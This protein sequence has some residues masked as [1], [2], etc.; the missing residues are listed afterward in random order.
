[1]AYAILRT[2]K[3]TT[4]GNVAASLQHNFRERPTLNADPERTPLNE[5]HGATST[6]QAMG[7]LRSLLPERRRKDAVL[8]IEYFCGASPE[9]WAK[10]DRAAQRAF[11]DRS[12]AWL[13]E[14]HGADRVIAATVQYD[15]T[16]PHLAAYV[17]PLT[18]DGRLSAKDFLGGRD[19]LR[20]MQT[21]YA[22]RMADLGLERGIE[23]SCATHQRVKHHYAQIAHPAKVPAI[24]EAQLT[25]RTFD[26]PGLRGKLGI[27]SRT[28]TPAEV[29]QRL[30]KVVHQALHSIDARGATAAQD[31]RRATELARTAQ[32]IRQQAEAAVKEL[33]RQVEIHR[34]RTN[35]LLKI[36]LEGGEPLRNLQQKLEQ[37]RLRQFEEH[38]RAQAKEKGRD[39]DDWSR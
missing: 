21:E 15:E 14:R 32:R 1:M 26:A 8:A 22:A 31:R 24:T 39:R 27:G 29:A 30:T 38:Q 9:W 5:H 10:V 3:L 19:K 35:Q 11:F 25:P 16:S 17:V 6:D 2:K 7:R 13:R 18:A 23:G 36:V 28:E 37:D 34:T 20:A 4:L 33:V 12:L